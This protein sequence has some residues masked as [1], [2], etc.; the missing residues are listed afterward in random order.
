MVSGTPVDDVS[1]STLGASR[2][3]TWLFESTDAGS[4][5]G[6]SGAEVGRQPIRDRREGDLVEELVARRRCC[7][8]RPPASATSP[9]R[10]PPVGPD[11]REPRPPVRVGADRE[12]GERRRWAERRQRFEPLADAASTSSTSISPTTTTA[13]LSGRYRRRR[14]GGAARASWLRWL[15]R[16]RSGRALRSRVSSRNKP[17]IASLI[18]PSLLC[19]EFRPRRAPRRVPVDLHR[20]NVA[21]VSHSSS[22]SSAVL[23]GSASRVCT[24]SW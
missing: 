14:S 23:S 17:S 24:V 12:V 19:S 21:A 16:C 1:A 13:A 15:C 22:T 10:T 18:R 20:S 11:R 6:P 5:G 8:V 9:R 3:L 4:E 7:R 2:P